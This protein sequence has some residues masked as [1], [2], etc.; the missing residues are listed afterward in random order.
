M[1][2][3]DVANVVGSRPTGW[4]RDR[5]GAGRRFAE[6]VQRAVA[7]GAVGAPVTLVVEGKARDGVASG[8]A[9]DGIAVVHAPR[10]GDD[11][12]AEISAVHGTAATVVTADRGLAARVRQSGSSA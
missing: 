2:I 3:V 9:G 8:D 1:L 12:I 7:T 6:Q 5:A 4:W 10:S 11:T